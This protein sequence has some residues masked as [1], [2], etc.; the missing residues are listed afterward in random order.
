[1]NIIKDI[2]VPDI[3]SRTEQ[4]HRLPPSLGSLV[5]YR[6][7]DRHRDYLKTSASRQFLAS[8]NDVTI[9]ELDRNETNALKGP[10][11][12]SETVPNIVNV[13]EPIAS[14]S[15]EHEEDD[16]KMSYPRLKPD[17]MTLGDKN[18]DSMLRMRMMTLFPTCGVA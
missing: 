3:A 13:E 16:E 17:E 1:M 12:H 10:N 2:P 9:T 4:L 5:G 18:A 14:G 7:L 6:G 15:K 8:Q 11:G